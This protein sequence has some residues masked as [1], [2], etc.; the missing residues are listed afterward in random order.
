MNSEHQDTRREEQVSGLPVVVEDPLISQLH[1]IEA[2][3]KDVGWMLFTV[4]VAGF[5][6]PGIIGFPFVV[7]G[8]LILWPN[9]EKRIISWAEKSPKG[10]L[11][12]G[13]KQVVRFVDDLE[14]RYPLKP[15]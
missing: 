15:R 12:G 7:A 10:M 2:L 13:I 5:I 1:R 3:P 8:G 14:R 6:L 9:S 4:G 11:R